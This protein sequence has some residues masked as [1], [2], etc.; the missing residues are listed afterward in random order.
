VAFLN[1]KLVFLLYRAALAA[2]FPLIVVYAAIRILRNRKYLDSLKERIG[3]IS[4]SV[5]ET[6]QGGI[7]IH[8]VS[9]GEVLAA[10]PLIQKLRGTLPYTSISL[11]VTTLAGRA[12]A[13]EK[14]CKEVDSIFYAPADF[15]FFVRRVL[16]VLRPNLLVLIET[17][18][19]PNLWR[20]TK[21]TGA[22]LVVVNGR[23][24]D[25]AWPR[26]RRLRWFFRPVLQMA[27]CI[28][29]QSELARER[30]LHLG[31]PS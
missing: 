15:A 23:I 10:A 1:R 2:A 8:A 11:S 28:L 26:Y 30:F 16:R 12:L 19:W 31:A 4:A 29:A 24:S 7:W 14:L 3:W 9:V 6:K 17:E 5:R 27:D 13:D 18:I 25:R 21:R 20:E 22:G